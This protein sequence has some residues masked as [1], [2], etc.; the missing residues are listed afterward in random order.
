ME[1]SL[2]SWTMDSHEA[3]HI[4]PTETTC[5]LLGFIMPEVKHRSCSQ[6]SSRAMIGVNATQKRLISIVRNALAK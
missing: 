1:T 6:N 3:G 4:F 5:Q 2:G